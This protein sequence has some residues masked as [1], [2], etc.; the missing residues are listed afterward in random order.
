[1]RIKFDKGF[2]PEVIG[3][4]FAEYV[5]EQGLIIGTVNIYVQTYD[6]NMKAERYGRDEEYLLIQPSDSMTEEYREDVARLRRRRITLVQNE[7]Q[8]QKETA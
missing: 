8:K 2:T 1:M 3:Q 7:E 5:R 4:I 6:E